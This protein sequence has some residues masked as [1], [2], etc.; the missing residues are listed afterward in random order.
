MARNQEGNL[1]V[2]KARILLLLV[3]CLIP[4]GCSQESVI[5]NFT[6]GPRGPI[7]GANQIA[8]RYSSHGERS[9][10]LS[11]EV[12]ELNLTPAGG[13]DFDIV[14]GPEVLEYSW[15]TEGNFLENGG[16]VTYAIERDQE[17]L[18]LIHVSI[19][20]VGGAEAVTGSGSLFT[21]RFHALEEGTTYID[22]ANTEILGGG[23]DFSPM[24][25]VLWYGGLVVVY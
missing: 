22:F 2:Q 6:F 7:E 16:G 23:P 17:N 20:Q 8:L 21:I 3:F 1:K 9:L 10:I 13:F 24:G 11:V 15:V 25:G 4:L 12:E 14:F 5:Y 18:G 19:R